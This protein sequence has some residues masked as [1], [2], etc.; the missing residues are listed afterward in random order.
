MTAGG[1]S[2]QVMNLRVLLP[3]FPPNPN[4]TTNMQPSPTMERDLGRD[5]ALNPAMEDEYW[6]ERFREEPY[7]E[8]DYTLDDYAPAYRH[9]Y[10][11]RERFQDR[12]WD[13]AEGDLQS[14]WEKVKGK[15]RLGWDRAKHAARAAWDRIER[16]IPGD[17][18]G[19]GK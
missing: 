5:T 16:A 18:D 13:E 10:T 1:Q 9:G 6:S 7:Y 15:S 2:W 8:R 11:S 4:P 12:D 14:S 19:D 17:S 3:G